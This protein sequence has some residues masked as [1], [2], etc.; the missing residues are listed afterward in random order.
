MTLP[1]TTY[2]AE[3]SNCHKVVQSRLK[4]GQCTSCDSY[5]QRTGEIRPE[6]CWNRKPK[7]TK[8]RYKI[9]VALEE[10]FTEW[11]L[12]QDIPIK[13]II[14]RFDISRNTIYGT[15]RRLNLEAVRR[16]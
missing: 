2:P 13:A 11:Y 1:V 8:G 15:A 5:Q 12:D 10:E 6:R 9:T 16:V 3:C 7:I 4:R 14:Q